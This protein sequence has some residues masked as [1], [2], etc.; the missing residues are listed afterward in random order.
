[1]AEELDNIHDFEAKSTSRTIPLG[2]QILFW[3]LIAW[4]IYYVV[5]Y[6]PMFSGWSQ[7]SAYTKS[8]GK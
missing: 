5:T 4:G 8:I 7:E 1:M 2:W 3:A 6:T